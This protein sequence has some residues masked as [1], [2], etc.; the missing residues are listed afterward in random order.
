M[1]CL[2]Q[3]W[4]SPSCRRGSQLNKDSLLRELFLKQEVWKWGKQ[5][6]HGQ[7]KKQQ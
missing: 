6:N 4:D 7:T 2:L 1:L 5:I 3:E